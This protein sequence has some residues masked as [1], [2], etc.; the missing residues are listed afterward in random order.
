MKISGW[1]RLIK[2]GFYSLAIWTSRSGPSGFR[3]SSSM[4][5]SFAFSL[6]QRNKCVIVGVDSR[7][8]NSKTA[9]LSE[10]GV[11]Y[12]RNHAS[13]VKKS[14]IVMSAVRGCNHAMTRDIRNSISFTIF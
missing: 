2:A 1:R 14:S 11:G 3:P 7:K 12:F 13:H 4:K 9:S 10:S 6:L 8:Y 5:T